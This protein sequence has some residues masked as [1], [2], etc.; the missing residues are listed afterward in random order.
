[1]FGCYPIAGKEIPLPAQDDQPEIHFQSGTVFKVDSCY[2]DTIKNLLR[3]GIDGFVTEE[4]NLADDAV[5]KQILKEAVQFSSH[6][7]MCQNTSSVKRIEFFLYPKSAD[8]IPDGWVVFARCF[9]DTGSA[10]I[11][12][13]EYINYAHLEAQAI[14]KDKET[15]LNIK[16]ALDHD[17]TGTKYYEAGE[18]EKAISEFTRAIDKHPQDFIAFINRG[19]AYF[20]TRQYDKAVADF[21][22]AIKISPQD[23]RAFNNR[24]SAY[25]ELGKF[26]EAREDYIKAIQLDPMYVEAYFNRGTFYAKRGEYEKAIADLEKATEINP[27]YYKASF[28]K[29]L[30]CEKVGRWTEAMDAYGGFLRHAPV[31]LAAQ[32]KHAQERIDILKGRQ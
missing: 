28:H 18:N 26:E 3:V 10:K 17:A 25:E 24:A 13:V 16:A 12:W 20:A 15:A 19:T 27:Q 31:Q 32:R 8:I 1:M 4:T 9:V 2:L 11:R 22:Q 29:A 6:Q 23:A 21:S 14:E 5:A 7:T 30:A